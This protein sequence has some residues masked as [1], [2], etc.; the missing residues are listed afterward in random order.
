MGSVKVSKE[1]WKMQ[2][3]ISS[4]KLR[5]IFSIMGGLLLLVFFLFGY[6]YGWGAASEVVEQRFIEAMKNCICMV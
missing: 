1:V 5:V 3:D 2:I 4:T 6:S